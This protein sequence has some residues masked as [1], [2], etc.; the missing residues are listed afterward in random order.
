[1][2]TKPE[3]ETLKAQLMTVN[4]PQP[5]SRPKKLL[6]GL[7]FA[8]LLIAAFE[9]LLRLALGPPPPPV[10]VFN[11]LGDHERWL[12]EQ[13]GKVSTTYV[14]I[15]PP[16]PFPAAWDG[17]RCAV[18]GGSSV[19]AGTPSLPSS[20]EFPALI[21]RELG[22]PVINLGS[23]GLD[24]FDHRAITEEM[25][26]WPWTCMIVYAGHN[27][28]G[29][30]FFQARYGD[31]LSGVGARTRAGL[32]HFQLFVQLHRLLAPVEGLPRTVMGRGGPDQHLIDDTRWW[33][34][35]RYLEANARRMVWLAKQKGVRTIIVSPVSD[36][37]EVP[38]QQDCAGPDC[39]AEVYR[40]AVAASRTDGAQA[41]ALLRR[42]RDLD[43]VALRAPTAAQEAFRRVAEEEGA[44]FV[45]AEAL[46]PQEPGVPVPAQRLFVD[47]VHFS[48]EGHQ[49]MARVLAPVVR[50]VVEEA[51][52][53]R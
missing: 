37:L 2:R 27:D 46:L 23:P 35:L 51:E 4:P 28:F 29:N 20:G 21:G 22:I 53:G 17:P 26:A 1:M 18:H 14:D 43:R 6:F 50:Q 30:A 48:A 38:G 13:D 33:A 25:L 8:L 45:D 36:V 11:A 32:E 19:H 39:A 47:G 3:G 15:Q 44:T 42:A 31:L 16:E 10:R 12:V 40:Q 41:A 5:L 34:A 24:T 52:A 9:G 49:A 7:A